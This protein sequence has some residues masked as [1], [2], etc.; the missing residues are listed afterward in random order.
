MSYTLSA[1]AKILVDQIGIKPNIVLKVNGLDAIFGQVETSKL[2]RIGD[3]DLVI[4]GSWTIGGVLPDEN[5]KPWMSLQR[6]SKN[7]S[8]QLLQ[9]KGGSSSI[10]NVNIELIDKDNQVTKLFQPGYLIDDIIAAEAIVYMGF[11]E[12]SFPEDYIE[13]F[14]GVIDQADFGASSVV[15]TV[16]HPDQLKR[17]EIFVQSISK[18]SGAID[19]SVTSITLEDASTLILPSTDVRAFI[20]VDDEIIEY[21]GIST[22]TLTGCTRGQENTIATTHDDQNET[23][24]YYLLSGK[25]IQTALKVMLSDDANTPIES[26]TPIGSVNYLTGVDI[27]DGAYFFNETNIEQRL[28]LVVGDL[29]TVSGSLDDFVDEPIT[30]FGTNSLGSYIRIAAS[31]RPSEL[32]ST[33]TATLKSKYNVLPAGAGLGMQTK[34]VDVAGHEF[35][36]TLHGSGFPTYDVKIKDTY[37]GKNLIESQLYAPAGLYSL[38]RKGRSGVG[39]T[40]PPLAV[41]EVKTLDETN[42][43]NPRSLQIKRTVNKWF[44]NNIIFKYELDSLEDR[45]LDNKVRLSTDSTTRI[46]TGTKT[47]PIVSDGLRSNPETSNLLDRVARN[48]LSRYQFA[49]D[50][51]PNVQIMPSVGFNIEVGDVLIFGSEFLQVSDNKTGTRKFKPRLMEVVQKKLNINTL[52]IRIDLLDTSFG[53]DTRFAVISPSSNI[54]TGSTDTII[55]LKQSYSTIDGVDE[56]EKWRDFQDQPLTIHSIDWSFE[57]VSN[58]VIHPT[59]PNALL[60]DTPLS[61]APSKDFIVDVATYDESSDTL[62][63]VFASINPTVLVDVGNSSTSFDVPVGE[64]LKFFVDGV[65]RVHNADFSND[66]GQ[67]KI[68]SVIGQTITCEDMGFTP[69]NGDG[70]E[71]IGFSSDN[72]APYTLI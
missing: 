25:P 29:L 58:F 42:V 60:L 51:I 41:E 23:T 55:I 63:T 68:T 71:L 4:D 15:V 57:E 20:R 27:I 13:I 66:S 65:I 3:T 45:Y 70:I 6:T 16:G 33:A 38:P 31:G 64:E 44:Y 72:G 7:I 40:S 46:K 19:A 18:L 53:L 10:S 43:K 1:K 37:E 67:V 59:I 48:L 47:L 50:F 49:A 34:Q 2:I 17:R 8:Q 5:S 69:A 30:G 21:T 9:D 32:T 54:S 62:K 14:S 28:G 35:V 39:V 61:I 52:D 24:S 22:N 36:E 12:G 26:D 11:Q 56:I